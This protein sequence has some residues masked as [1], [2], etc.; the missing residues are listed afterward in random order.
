MGTFAI[1][2]YYCGVAALYR[3]V[4][5]NTDIKICVRI[6]LFK[7]ISVSKGVVVPD[8]VAGDLALFET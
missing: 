7:L 5:G 3:T 2:V 6:T 4:R 8:K 1:S